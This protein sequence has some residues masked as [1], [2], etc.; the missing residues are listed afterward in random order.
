MTFPPRSDSVEFAVACP[1]SAIVMHREVT[2][3]MTNAPLRVLFLCTGNS[4]RSQMAEALLNQKGQGRFR[5]E[6][7]GS[8]PA[9]RVNPHAIEALADMGIA[10][11]GRTPRGIGRPR[12]RTLGHRYHGVRQREGG[13]PR[14]SRPAD[15]AHWGMDDP[16]EVQGTAEETQRAFEEARDLL[17]R[18]IDQLIATVR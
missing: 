15:V 11:E 13:V 4:A 5:A 12:T 18:R 7:A 10:W 8:R 3:D 1:A 9:P 2:L 14:L 17:A 6:S 16:A